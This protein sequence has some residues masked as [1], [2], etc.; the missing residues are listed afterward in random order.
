MCDVVEYLVP[1]GRGKGAGEDE[2][3]GQGE[4]EG[5]EREPVFWRGD[6]VVEHADDLVSA[7]QDR[8]VTFSCGR[9]WRRRASRA[10]L[11]GRRAGLSPFTGACT[12]FTTASPSWFVK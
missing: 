7:R 10:M 3:V 9:P 11:C 12:T 5:L 2:N 1:L 8:G 4:R 6:G